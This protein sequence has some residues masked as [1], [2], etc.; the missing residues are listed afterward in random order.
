MKKDP[1]LAHYNINPEEEMKGLNNRIG[2]IGV[3]E[4][5]HAA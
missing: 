3:V 2:E 5:A 4:D 1:S